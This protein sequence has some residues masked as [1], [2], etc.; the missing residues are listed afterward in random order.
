MQKKCR[1]GERKVEGYGQ[2]SQE[3]TQQMRCL[4]KQDLGEEGNQTPQK[5]QQLR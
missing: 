4:T 1:G 3:R 5:E 2:L